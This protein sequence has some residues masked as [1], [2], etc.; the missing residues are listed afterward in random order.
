MNYKC[1]LTSK[2]EYTLFLQPLDNN[3]GKQNEKKKIK[4]TY[5]T[6]FF[7]LPPFFLHSFFFFLFFSFFSLFTRELTSSFLI[8]CSLMAKPST[9]INLL[10]C[11]KLLTPL[12]LF[13]KS[14]I[15]DHEVKGWRKLIATVWMH[16]CRVCMG[17]ENTIGV[18]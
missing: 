8:F 13:L 1:G 11:S 15:T 17:K 6:L 5:P 2:H 14:F 18:G 16:G 7:F 10:S 12:P 4:E 3:G 9:I